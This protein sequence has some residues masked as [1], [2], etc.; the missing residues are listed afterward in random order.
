M[1]NVI[2]CK[3]CFIKLVVDRFEKYFKNYTYK[4]IFYIVF[5]N[6]LDKN[7]EDCMYKILVYLYNIKN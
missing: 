5:E 2:D 3:I 7:R 4:L 6:L 1:D